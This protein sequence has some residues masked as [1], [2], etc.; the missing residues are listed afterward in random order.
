L[1]HPESRTGYKHPEVPTT[2]ARC[3]GVP[4]DAGNTKKHWVHRTSTVP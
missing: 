1:R 3:E 2:D 4:E